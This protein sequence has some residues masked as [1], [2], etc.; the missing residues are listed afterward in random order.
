M[1]APEAVLALQ[2]A[3]REA[4]APHHRGIVWTRAA[5][6]PGLLPLLLLR[7]GA[8]LAAIEMELSAL[9]VTASLRG[10]VA[11]GVL[12][13]DGAN[14]DELVDEEAHRRST[15]RTG[16]VVADRASRTGRGRLAGAT[17]TCWRRRAET[18][19]R[20]THDLPAQDRRIDLLVHG[21]DVLTVDAAGTVVT[22]GAV[23][24]REGEIVEVGPAEGL[25]SA[26]TRPT[27][28]IDAAR[29]PRPA[30][31]DQ[32]AHPS[33]D[34]AAARPRR[35]RHAP[36]LPGPGDPARG[37]AALAEERGGGRP[38]SRSPR[39]CGPG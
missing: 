13:V 39:A 18:A 37:R 17:A 24:V 32:H 12:V 26:R 23:A 11:G 21:G 10:L 14:A 16:T 2:R 3:A 5:F 15:T 19:R 33:R 9:L 1:S 25:R 34:D 7:R 31:A 20:S 4:G 8:G 36:G 27:E 28:S 38:R 29:L 30:R 6:Q 22:D 35:R